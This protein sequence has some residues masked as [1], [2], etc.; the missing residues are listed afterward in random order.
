MK[1]LD[2]Y[3]YDVR[4]VDQK[5]NFPTI[6][7]KTTNAPKQSRSGEEEIQTSKFN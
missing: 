3:K 7:Q 6:S 5:R 2:T 4:G 1:V